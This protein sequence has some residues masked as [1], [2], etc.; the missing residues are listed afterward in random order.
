LRNSIF[1]QYSLSYKMSNRFNNLDIGGGFS[2]L[3]NAP[4]YKMPLRFQ[5][6][7]PTRTYPFIFKNY[8]FKRIFLLQNIT[9]V[10]TYFINIHQ[11]PSNIIIHYSLQIN[12][13][14]ASSCLRYFSKLRFRS[15]SFGI[16]YPFNLINQHEAHHI[17]LQNATTIFIMK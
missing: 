2:L 16:K 13:D 10:S 6:L 8:I 4:C 5:R 1:P 17:M 11:N 15:Y 14:H 7:H 3:Q 9:L 12:T